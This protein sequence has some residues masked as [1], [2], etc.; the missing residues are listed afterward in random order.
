MSFNRV[1][2]QTDLSNNETIIEV[3]IEGETEVL[4]SVING[5]L[6]YRWAL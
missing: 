6:S 3:L 1:E 2:T 4:K 5:R